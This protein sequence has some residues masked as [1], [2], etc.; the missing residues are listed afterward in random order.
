MAIYLSHED[1]KGLIRMKDILQGAEQAFKDC[2]LG[3]ATNSPRQR[4]GVPNG[5]YRV[6]SGAVPSLGGMGSKGGLHQ[7]AVPPGIQKGYDV[8][9]LYSTET[10]ELLALICT[11]LITDYRTGAMGAVS[12]KYLARSDTNVVGVLGSGRQARSQLAAVVLV[13]P[14]KRVLVYSPN[15][16]HRI[17]YANEM[18]R[19]LGIDVSPTENPKSVVESA[20]VLIA[21]TNSMDAVFDGNWIQKGTHIVSIRSSHKLDIGTGTARREIDDRTVE[22]SDFIA[23]DSLDQAVMQESPELMGAI[24]QERVVELGAVVAGKAQGRTEKEQIT[25][26]KSF[27]MGLQDVAASAKVYERAIEMDKGLNLP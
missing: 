24:R 1:V 27:G 9:I 22:R 20:D 25:L 23:V 13:R 2:G 19:E 18:S 14:I 10:G 6:M 7:F 16:A 12:T 4:L 21:A 8:N 3:S 17:G 5:V 15:P 11:S 26:F